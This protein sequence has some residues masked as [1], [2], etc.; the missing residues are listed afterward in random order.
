MSGESKRKK[1]S[2]SYFLL[3]EKD[4]YRVCKNFYL[5]T[6]VVSQK[7]VYNILDKKDKV[8]GILK[9]DGC[10][11]HNKH[12]RV[13]EEQQEEVIARFNSF[14]VVDSHYCRA[15]TNKKYLEA[16]LT[17]EKIYNLYKQMCEK[18]KNT[19]V[20]SKYCK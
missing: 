14:P 1:S 19:Y 16:G 8:T 4:S 18:E 11:K 6:L 13:T 12:H 2:Y 17:I 3:K 9:A 7:M 5:S 15:K 20:K 10:G